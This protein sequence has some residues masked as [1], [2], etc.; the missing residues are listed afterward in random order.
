VHA[1]DA[2]FGRLLDALDETGLSDDTVVVFIGDHG[3]EF[4]EHGAHRHSTVYEEALHVPLVLR[5]PGVAGATI[6]DPVSTLYVLPWLLSAL[7]GAV[8]CFDPTSVILAMQRELAAI[9]DHHP[10]DIE[11]VVTFNINE[12]GVPPTIAL[13]FIIRCTKQSAQR[14]P[15]KSVACNGCLRVPRQPVTAPVLVDAG[16]RRAR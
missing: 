11:P 4:G 5:I 1:S 8:S 7:L 2:E 13:S 12:C 6:S 3:E 14:L 16:A 10:C 15:I 9:H